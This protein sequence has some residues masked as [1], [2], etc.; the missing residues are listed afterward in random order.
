M[1]MN[2]WL[3]LN[4]QLFDG[5]EGAAAGE[6]TQT[7]ADITN[8][9]F[10]KRNSNSL[11]DVVYGKQVDDTQTDLDESQNDDL[12]S[13]D[14]KVSF[15]DLIKGEYKE[16]FAKEVEDIVKKRFKAYARDRDALQGLQPS[17]DLLM[18][19]YGLE[20]G[21]TEGLYNALSSDNALFESMAD[22]R[23]MSVDT[24]RSQLAIEA[25]NQRLR[26][27]REAYQ[28]QREFE[29]LVNNCRM[30]A[31]NLKVL[32]PNLDFDEEM[33]NPHMIDMITRGISFDTAYKAVHFDELTRGTLGYAVQKVANDVA[34]NINARNKRPIEN[35]TSSQAASNVRRDVSKFTKADRAEIVRRARNGIRI[36][37]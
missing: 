34:N 4:L 28:R 31:E 20:Q 2:K 1:I 35:G 21:D 6:G 37:L 9:S 3:E 17:I 22:D 30:E 15:K 18:S 25:E 33:N 24:L 27:D 14:S 36:E 10:A 19:R 32:Y 5:S 16:D 11:A 12:T 8:S 29:E 26:A 7:K 23:G 13:N